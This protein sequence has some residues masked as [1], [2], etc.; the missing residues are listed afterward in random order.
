[1]L[2]GTLEYAY[3]IYLV[4]VILLA[5]LLYEAVLDTIVTNLCVCVCV[6]AC[7]CARARTLA[8]CVLYMCTSVFMLEMETLYT[9]TT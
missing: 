8:I 5:E 9:L 3:P 7:A 2:Y 4:D 6:C 1:M